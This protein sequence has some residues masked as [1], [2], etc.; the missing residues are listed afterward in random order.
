M[1]RMALESPRLRVAAVV[2]EEFGQHFGSRAHA[3]K[4]RMVAKFRPIV[5]RRRRRGAELVGC[6]REHLEQRLQSLRRVVLDDARLVENDTAKARHVKLVQSVVVRDRDAIANV[7]AVASMRHANA[8]A[9]S[10]IHRLLGHCERCQNQ[11]VA[12]RLT[13]DCIGPGQLHAALA[14]AGIGEDRRSSAP[15][16]PCRK[17]ALMWE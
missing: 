11:Y 8:D 12:A 1:P 4:L 3:E 14:E 7:C 17:I 9:L 13:M 15:Q 10:F 16:R 2:D 6:R 5:R